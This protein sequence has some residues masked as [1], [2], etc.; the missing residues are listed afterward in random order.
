MSA[1]LLPL[2]AGRPPAGGICCG[3]DVQRFINWFEEIQ[4]GGVVAA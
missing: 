1:S 3:A 2:A 4:V